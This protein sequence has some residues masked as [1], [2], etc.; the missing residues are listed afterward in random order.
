[1]TFVPSPQQA[2]IFQEIKTGRGSIIVDSVAGS[3]KTTAIIE[4]IMLMKGSVAVVA[5]NK[6]ISVELQSKVEAKGS[7]ARA[8]T[9]HSFGY[10]A[11]RRVAPQVKLDANKVKNLMV[12]MEVPEHLAGFVGKAVSMAKQRAIGV[13]CP[14][15]DQAAW[16]DMVDHY[17][18]DESLSADGM[19][20]R[21]Y[22][23]QV[24]EGL[25]WAKRVLM[26][27]VEQD[28]SIIDFDDMIYAPL[29][30]DVKMWQNDWI[31][32]DEAQD[33]NPARRALAKKMLKWGGRAVFVGDPRQA[34][35][36]F[37]GADNDS[38]DIIARE[39]A[40][41]RMPLTVTYRCPKAVVAHA[42][43]WVQH[44][45]AHESAPMGSVVGMAWENFEKL[46]SDML[47]PTSAVLCRNTKP[48]VE[49]AFSLIRRGIACHVE[50]RDI[51][52]QL[53]ALVGKWKVKSLDALVEKLQK[54]REREIQKFMAKG[55]EERAEGVSDRVE[56]VLVIVGSL[57]PGS[58]VVDLRKAIEN[59][60]G[61]TPEGRA[62]KNLTLST[63]H[64]AK[65]REWNRVYLL[66]RERY[67]PSKFA[68]QQWQIDQEI[69]L[70]YV[71]VT[72][73]K[74]EL[75]EVAVAVAV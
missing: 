70:I 40:C 64:K 39:F 30:H 23:E 41:K 22:E 16:Q 4:S 49:L 36:G 48:L 46:E 74:C 17:E 19:T 69:N 12:S 34:I 55:L 20:V 11:W 21:S 24:S 27:S 32:V 56:T 15:N 38:L 28:H 58:S 65:G 73:A 68:R 53:L 75:V 31:C 60:F 42:Q 33:T 9:F 47:D 61:D 10:G 25:D 59:L 62:S 71:A 35:Y 29:V 1:M 6:S 26:A 72:R 50:G 14:F 67:M 18:L 57:T 43:Q 52:A 63:V 13:L 7:K 66:G 5:Y 51:G 37:T 3:G 54:Y 44:I 8:G 2:A 45:Q